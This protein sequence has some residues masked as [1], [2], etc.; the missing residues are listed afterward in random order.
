MI[1]AICLL[2]FSIVGSWM[3]IDPIPSYFI[4]NFPEIIGRFLV[5]LHYVIATFPPFV[6][7]FVRIAPRTALIRYFIL[8][9]EI[10]EMAI[11]PL[12]ADHE[13]FDD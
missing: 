7:I 10:E 8:I 12:G 13:T 2:I 1:P 4:R 9:G 11:T 3:M 5:A 6:D